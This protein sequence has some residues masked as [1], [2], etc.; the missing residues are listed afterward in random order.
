DA[1]IA[2]NYSLGPVGATNAAPTLASIA[3][4]TLDYGAS[5]T[6]PLSVGDSDTALNVLTL[7]G[8]AANSALIPTGNI[9]FTGTGSTRTNTIT[10]AAG[11]TGTTMVTVTVSDGAATAARNFNLTVLTQVETWRKQY[12]GTTANTGAAADDADPDG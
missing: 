1:Q 3:D 7:S 6:I 5:A 10:P 8:T 12:F 2:G 4:Q 9:V 11:M